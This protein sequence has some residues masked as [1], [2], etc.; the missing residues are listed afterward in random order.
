MK[1]M[2]CC[3]DDDMQAFLHGL[4]CFGSKEI[5]KISMNTNQGQDHSF[6]QSESRIESQLANQSPVFTR[7]FCPNLNARIPAYFRV[8]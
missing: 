6:D 4:F 1:V 7:C 8:F 3:V 5:Y 2:R